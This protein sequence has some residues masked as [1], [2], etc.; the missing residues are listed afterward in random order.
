MKVVI[1][2]KPSVAR[3]LAKVLGASNSKDGYIEGNGY[4][5]TWAFGHLIGLARPEAYGY[6]YWDAK[7]L[8]M[9][10][11]K[12]LLQVRQIKENGKYKSDPGVLKQL[13][14][15]NEL[16]SN[17]SEIIVATD[18]G[19]EGELIFRYIY[20][21][22]NCNK[23]FKRLWISSQTD[24]A[25]KRGFNQLKPGTDYDNLYFSAECRS[26]SD[27]LIG[28]NATQALSVAAGNN[29]VYSL[30]RVQTPT[31]SMICKRFLENK[32]FKP[33]IFFKIEI[34]LVK[35]NQEFKAISDENFK[36]KEAAVEILNKVQDVN[37]GFSNGAQIVKVEFKT[38]K[39]APP[40]LHDLSSLQ[41]ESNI[42][43]G[44]TAEQTL[45]IAQTL[46]ENKFISYPRTGSRYI[47]EDVFKD[48]N[49]LI[50]MLTNHEIFSDVAKN[51]CQIL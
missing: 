39:E 46:Y 50:K 13:K 22:L 37:S 15:I 1:A 10:P 41:Q 5:F 19:R 30:G 40:L 20:Q 11:E 32:F 28:L 24:E 18:A 12:F 16:F 33:E 9:L 23:P 6:T 3:D 36:T 2:E 42:I 51:Y 45:Q 4:A 21:Y 31:L 49:D 38:V 26:Q 44:Y 48:I 17:A 43:F 35:N 27:W 29:S 8:P 7:N 25:I 47:G 14:V 34:T